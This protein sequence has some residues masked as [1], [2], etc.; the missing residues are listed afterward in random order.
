MKEMVFLYK[1]NV[2][3]RNYCAYIEK[4]SMRWECGHYFG[5]VVLHG[6]CYC[7]HDFADYDNIKTILTRRE[8][9]QLKQFS[10]EI[11][12]LGYGIKKGDE[13]YQ[14]GLELCK[15]IQP[16]YD[17]LLSKDNRKF[18]EKIQ[19]E[20]I[21]YLMDEY[22]LDKEDIEKI[23]DEYYLDY[24]DRG[25]VGGIYED[26]YDLGY[27]TAWNYGILSKENKIIEDYFDFERFGEDLLREDE[28][29]ELNDGRIV[30]LCY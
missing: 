5:D 20:E 14:K 13:R 23:F 4:K 15:A 25:I 1:E 18:F 3:D 17:K 9:E 6:A 22:S 28:Y 8:Y 12:S 30:S 19:E 10:A 11:R 7:G 29:V 2:D 16:I 24:R 21:E 26:T 27:E